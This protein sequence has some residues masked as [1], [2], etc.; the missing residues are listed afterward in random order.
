MI[1]NL[2]GVIDYIIEN[3]LIAKGDKVG[4]GVSGGQDSMSLLY[5]L[6]SIAAEAGFSIVAVHVNHKIRPTARKEATFVANFCKKHGIDFVGL[7]VDV[8]LFAKT[9]KMGLEQASRV[10]RYEAFDQIIAKRKL[11]RFATAHHQSDQAET[12]LLNI[13]RGSGTAGAS[14]MAAKRGPYIRPFL[15]TAKSDIVGYSYRMQIPYMADESNEDN[16]FRRN[17][18]RNQ[19]IPA[20]Q[21]EW[22]NVEKNIIDFGKNCRS[23]DDY[24]NSLV[25]N[26]SFQL[27]E[28]HVRI[29]LSLFTYPDAV[30]SRVVISGFEKLGARDDI[31]KKHIELVAT[32]ART[33]ENGSKTDLPGGIFAIKEYE[34]LA[35]VRKQT[36]AVTKVYSFKIGRT[37]F[38]EYGAINVSKTTAFRDAISRGLMAIDVDKLPRNAK[39]R[40]RKEGDMF[41]KFGGGT[42][43]LNSY[44]IDKKIPTRLRDRIPVL[45]VGNDIFAVAGVEISEKVK[46]DYETIE[47][48]VVEVVRD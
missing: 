29:P 22:R 20:L 32:L 2:D 47:A 48:Y 1:E 43:N 5:F 25:D 23:D 36:Q 15:E 3:K 24:L 7:T 8:P 11:N 4:V 38:A 19:I 35:I 13:F 26:R 41:T 10:K 37:A 34:Y 44:M 31:E 46:V 6:S 39:W 33:G 18:L 16:T 27:A 21:Q 40:T 30:V 14:G 42:K 28:H 12:I 45:A 17:F 9:N